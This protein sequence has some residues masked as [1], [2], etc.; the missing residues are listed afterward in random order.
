MQEYIFQGP[1]SKLSKKEA[2]IIAFTKIYLSHRRGKIRTVFD[3][4][5]KIQCVSLNK[6]LLKELDNLNNLRFR[7]RKYAKYYTNISSGSLPSNCDALRFFT[8]SFLPKQ[9][10]KVV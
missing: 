10:L 5:A 4:G 1:T 9:I 7:Q 3:A 2:K 8:Y 6:Y